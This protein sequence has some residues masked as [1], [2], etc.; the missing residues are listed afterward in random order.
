MNLRTGACEEG[1]LNADLN[2]E[3]PGLNLR[4]LGQ[5]SRYAYLVDHHPR[6]LR[7]TGI[8]KLDCDTGASLGSYSDG[9]QV[10]WYSEPWFAPRGA[11]NAPDAPQSRAGGAAED[12]GYVV[13]FCYRTD[14]REQQLHVFDARDVSA[15]PRVRLRVPVRV[16]VG[17][18][19]T[20][21]LPSE[22]AGL[23]E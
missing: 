16:P 13:V 6:M 9:E 18:H 17:F 12:D 11:V 4:K 1:A 14:T 21:A 19:A 5:R 20:F 22:C 3:F 2:V 10:A 15:G 8:R 7:W 23:F